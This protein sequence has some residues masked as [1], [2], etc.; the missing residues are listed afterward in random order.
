MEGV[1]T[2]FIVATGI[3]RA[4]TDSEMEF[5]F[6]SNLDRFRD[7]IFTSPFFDRFS[8][9]AGEKMRLKA[10]DIALMR[11]AFGWL[12]FSLFGEETGPFRRP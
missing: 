3:H 5:I 11:L 8:F 6:G 4:P 10:D 2:K 12:K 9:S 1:E 7:F